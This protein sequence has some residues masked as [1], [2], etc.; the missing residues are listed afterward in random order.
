MQ[1]VNPDARTWRHV[2]STGPTPEIGHGVRAMGTV[3]GSERWQAELKENAAVIA[4]NKNRM[5]GDVA[6]TNRRLA[7]ETGAVSF[8]ASG[9][10]RRAR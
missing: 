5:R 7:Q 2:E 8:V 6:F 1:K 3:D 4:A 10:P 9:S